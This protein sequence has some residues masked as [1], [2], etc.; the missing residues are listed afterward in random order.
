MNTQT[1]I[2]GNEVGKSSK[3]YCLVW[4]RISYTP[5]W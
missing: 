1:F 5:I 4:T 3:E 2:M